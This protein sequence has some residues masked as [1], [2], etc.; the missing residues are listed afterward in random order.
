ARGDIVHSE[1]VLPPD[2][3][4]DWARDPAELWKEAERAET[5]CDA[6]TSREYRVALPRGLGDAVLI[7]LARRLAR[8]IVR[9]FRCAADFS[10]HNPKARDGLDQPHVHIMTTTRR[11]EEE[12]LGNKCWPEW[13]DDRLRQYGL[14]T[15]AQLMRTIRARI[16]LVINAVLRAVKRP[17]RVDHLSYAAHG[18]P[19]AT[20]SS[21]DLRSLIDLGG[22]GMRRLHNAA[23]IKARPVSFLGIVTRR[24]GA[25]PTADV[26]ARHL[27]PLLGTAWADKGARFVLKAADVH[28]PTSAPAN[29]QNEMSPVT[30]LPTISPE[31]RARRRYRARK[32]TEPM[33]SIALPKPRPIASEG[34][35][36]VDWQVSN[37]VVPYDE[38]V[39]VEALDEAEE[40]EMA[41][42][43]QWAMLMS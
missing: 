38:Q 35:A 7:R 2:V 17:E 27:T 37:T 14:P 40:E 36:V 34:R 18:L 13:P 29:V 33:I 23:V 9:A 26:L 10:I 41:L 8:M 16:A 31:E 28:R 6:R 11:I 3:R 24:L 25:V 30:P 5:R 43:R 4:A 39:V 20:R 1:I 42:P 19:L 12:G 32:S 21:D 15:G 22:E